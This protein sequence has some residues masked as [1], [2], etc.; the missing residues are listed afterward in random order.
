M[1]GAPFV[2]WRSVVAQKQ[3]DVAEQGL[4]TDRLNKAIEGLG[5]EKTLNKLGRDISYQVSGKLFRK[6]EFQGDNFEVPEHAQDLQPTAWTNYPVNVVNLEVRLGAI[7]AME[8]IAQDSLR[9]HVQIMEI[10]CAYVRENAPVRMAR[11]SPHEVFDELTEDTSDGQGLSAEAAFQHSKYKDADTLGIKPTEFD[12]ENLERWARQLPKPRLD[13]QAV[14]IVIGRRNA[15]QADLESQQGYKIDLRD[16]NLQFC[17]LIGKFDDAD[18][19][20]SRM[21][22]AE[23]Q[24]SFRDCEFVRSSLQ[25]TR[26]AAIDLSFSD[27]SAANLSAAFFGASDL[28]WCRLWSS[29][30]RWTNFNGANLTA[31]DWYRASPYHVY[32]HQDADATHARFQNTDVT[33]LKGIAEGPSKQLWGGRPTKIDQELQDRFTK[34]STSLEPELEFRREWLSSLKE[35]GLKPPTFWEV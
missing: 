7:Y 26:A 31:T 25:A 10:L 20:Q 30:M 11:R 15:A 34:L 5:T 29:K 33:E 14:L 27:L 16:S 19:T 21:D 35:L 3:V 18:F 4:I 28:S 32:F 2:V 6:F 17:Q 22:G 24:G 1:I 23:L 13:I 8:R 9:D 12:Q